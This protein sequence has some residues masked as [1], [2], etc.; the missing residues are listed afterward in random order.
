MRLLY[1]FFR[2]TLTSSAGDA[3][4]TSADLGASNGVVHIINSVL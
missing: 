4:V 2:I 3:E 1:F